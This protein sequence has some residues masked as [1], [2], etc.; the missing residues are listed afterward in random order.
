MAIIIIIREVKA[1]LELLQ[2]GA[3]SCARAT[4]PSFI[5]RRSSHPS[6]N[7]LY[8]YNYCNLFLQEFRRNILAFLLVQISVTKVDLRPSTGLA[9]KLITSR[10][11]K[12]LQQT[13]CLVTIFKRQRL[14][15]QLSQESRLI[16]RKSRSSCNN[17]TR[18]KCHRFNRN[19]REITR[20]RGRRDRGVEPSEVEAGKD[21]VIWPSILV[22]ATINT[23]SSLVICQGAVAGKGSHIWLFLHL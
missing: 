6:Q 22:T 2:S 3:R 10:Y 13:S 14:K 8:H 12:L 11:L 7:L 23:K 9:L 4:R 20:E 15:R 21:R 17:Q 19:T 16:L 5:W 1:T 18:C